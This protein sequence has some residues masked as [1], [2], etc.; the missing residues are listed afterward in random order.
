M[1]PPVFEPGSAGGDVDIGERHAGDGDTDRNDGVR[2]AR[3]GGFRP[4]SSQFFDANNPAT[5]TT[6]TGP[7]WP[8]GNGLKA[9]W[10]QFLHVAARRVGLLVRV[11]IGGGGTELGDRSL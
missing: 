2:V 9:A 5:A 6:L 7:W 10:V 3:H 4:D 11:W 8:Y 1:L